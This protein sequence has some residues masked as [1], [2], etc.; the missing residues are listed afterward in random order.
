[1]SETENNAQGQKTRISRSS[2]WCIIIVVSIGVAI[3][4][5]VGLQVLAL[6]HLLIFGAI[7]V[8]VVFLGRLLYGIILMFREKGEKVNKKVG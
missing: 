4:L 7:F 2:I 1:V 8:P 3:S 6:K 5:C